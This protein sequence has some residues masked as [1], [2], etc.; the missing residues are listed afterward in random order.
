VGQWDGKCLSTYSAWMVQYGQNSYL[1]KQS[2]GGFHYAI[3]ASVFGIGLYAESEN[4]LTHKFRID[5]KQTAA[6]CGNDGPIPLST[7]VYKQ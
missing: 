2:G 3:G 5:F 7:L 1:D 6:M 4:T